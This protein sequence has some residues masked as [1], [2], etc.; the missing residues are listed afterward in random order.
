MI[1]APP[2]WNTYLENATHKKE[3]R[4]TISER[5]G[6]SP[7]TYG[8]ESI[9]SATIEA[10]L[11][12]PDMRIGNAVA[13][14]LTMTV[15]ATVPVPRMARV[16]VECR[17]ALDDEYTDYVTL[18]TFWVDERDK[19]SLWRTF[20]CYDAMLMFEQAFIDAE[21]EAGEWPIPM[22]AA[23]AEIC[24]RAGVEL[25]E[26][27][28]V[29]A[30]T[31]YVVPYTNDFTMREV[32]G[33]IAACHGG[34][35]TITSGGKLKLVVLQSPSNTPMHALG[36]NITRLTE[37]GEALTISKIT[38]YDDAE[39]AFTSGDDTG[40]HLEVD[41]PYAT[42]GI[43]DALCNTVDGILYNATLTPFEAEGARLNPLAELGDD[44]SV[45][46][47]ASV[48]NE[49]YITLGTHVSRIGCPG[50]QEIDH[51]YPYLSSI[52]RMKNRTVKLDANY[53]GTSIS[54]KDG[55]KIERSDGKGEAVFNSDTFAM[56]ALDG[57]LMA[58]KVY[59]DPVA[60]NYVF[61]G[62]LSAG[63]VNALSALIT[64]N[65]Y[66]EKANI[67]EVTVDQLDTST[68]VK[69]YLNED[70]SDVNYTKI[71]D[72]YIH[73][74]TAE[75]DGAETEQVRDRSNRPLYWIDGTFTAA[76]AEVTSYPVLA[77][78]YTE[79]IKRKIGFNLIDDTYVPTDVW[80]VGG[81]DGKDVLHVYKAKQEA[82]IKYVDKTG[83]VK[84]LTISENGFDFDPPF[85]IFPDATNFATVSAGT[86]GA[87]LPGM[88]VTFQKKT[89]VAFDVQIDATASE[90]L[91]VT[92]EARVNGEVHRSTVKRYTAGYKDQIVFNGLFDPVPAGTQTVDFRIFTST[93]TIEIAPKEYRSMLTIRNGSA[94]EAAPWPEANISDTIEFSGSE[95]SD[96][97]TV[98]IPTDV[99]IFISDGVEFDGD[100]LDD[101]LNTEVN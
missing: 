63:V 5:D 25:D 92:L 59:F 82:V 97:L 43:T 28:V 88:D 48:L 17:L 64:P 55:I 8:M 45:G 90:A 49:I 37:Q 84:S 61:D 12:A 73:F 75:T 76:S 71:F 16:T 77:Y 38:M 21:L 89:K 68:K 57:E 39:N 41:C 101:I 13:R 27:T 78:K 72:Q 40:Y 26:E 70:T 53:F 85:M 29:H 93:G 51:E 60:G 15:L 10:A 80:G 20:V 67:A 3:Y 69:N 52:Q 50:E 1:L 34:N 87:V 98:S 83:D 99:K 35:W 66:A 23:V 36:N 6:S 33:Y 46:G 58:D 96:K 95:L 65:I 91:T 22:G 54:R 7:E 56:R 100:E 2:N 30:G 94:T 4:I 18:G 86:G 19:G 14:K 74:I 32:L 24:A 47:I 31:D 81:G 44:V 62:T 9:Q 79:Y 11:F 42:Q